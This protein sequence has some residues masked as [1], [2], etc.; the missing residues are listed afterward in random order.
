MG[1]NVGLNAV[2]S[3]RTLTFLVR[4]A[5]FFLVLFKAKLLQWGTKDVNILELSDVPFFTCGVVQL[6]GLWF[7]KFM[8]GSLVQR[9]TNGPST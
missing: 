2:H 3:A 1:Q 5:A 8:M 7:T 4:S 6:Q 9:Q